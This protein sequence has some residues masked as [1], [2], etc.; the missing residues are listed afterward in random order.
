MKATNAEG[1][2]RGIRGPSL[3][4]EKIKG[5]KKGTLEP[6]FSAGQARNRKDEEGAKEMV[7]EKKQVAELQPSEEGTFP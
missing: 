4:S 3:T 6:S 2:Q 7:E 1:F 5:G